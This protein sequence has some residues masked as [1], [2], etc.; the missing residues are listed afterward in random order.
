MLVLALVSKHL[1]FA[2]VAGQVARLVAAENEM[3]HQFSEC[4]AAAA[5]AAAHDRRVESLQL[6]V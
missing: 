5:A 2:T 6:G 3:R 4:G 1:D